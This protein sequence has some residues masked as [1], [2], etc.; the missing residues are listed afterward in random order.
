MNNLDQRY[1]IIQIFSIGQSALNKVVREEM[2]GALWPNLLYCD[3][4][5]LFDLSPTTMQD[6]FDL[7]VL[8]PIQSS[9]DLIQ[10][11]MPTYINLYKSMW[12]SH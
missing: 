6:L 10:G 7:S 3:R 9:G 5:S 4:Q 1:L 2:L 11:D 12:V 8:T